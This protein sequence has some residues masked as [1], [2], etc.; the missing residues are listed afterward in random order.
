MLEAVQVLGQCKAQVLCLIPVAQDHALE[1]VQVLEAV[2]KALGQCEGVEG[3]PKEE[4]VEGLG[5][6]KVQVLCRIPV[7]LAQRLCLA[8]HSQKKRSTLHRA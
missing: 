6:C 2:G 3:G 5:K 1:A 7:A 8:E 4:V